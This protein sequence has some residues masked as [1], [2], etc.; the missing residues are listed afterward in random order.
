M[1]LSSGNHEV[2]W[3]ERG[4]EEQ[5]VFKAK[6]GGSDR[7]G[8]IERGL[9]ML[10]RFIYHHVPVTAVWIVPQGGLTGDIIAV[11]TQ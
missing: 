11:D 2:C 9:Y 8:W 1:C 10:L 7:K 4:Y 3:I 5:I 6:F